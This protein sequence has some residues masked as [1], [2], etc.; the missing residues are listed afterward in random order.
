LVNAYNP[1]EGLPV[2]GYHENPPNYGTCLTDNDEKGI[3]KRC[4]SHFSGFP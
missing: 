3:L 1:N 2:S 4:S